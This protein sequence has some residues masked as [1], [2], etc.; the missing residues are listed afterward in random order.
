MDLKTLLQNWECSQVKGQVLM[1]VVMIGRNDAI[2]NDSVPKVF[3]V[4][5]FLWDPIFSTFIAEHEA[6]IHL[7]S[8]IKQVAW[9]KIGTLKE[10]RPNL[11]AR[12]RAQV[13]HA[14]PKHYLLRGE[15]TKICCLYDQL[16]EVVFI[17][18]CF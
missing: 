7:W 9:D 16:S 12:I 8:E 2:C 10:C 14:Q 18:K 4:F 1:T 17:F 6:V 3:C 11:L 13:R 5:I 15:A